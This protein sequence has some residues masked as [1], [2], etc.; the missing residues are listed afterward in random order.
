MAR[1]ADPGPTGKIDNLIFY[2]M[3]GK[4]YVRSMPRHVKQTNATKAR[5]NEFA[6]ASTIG[7]SIRSGLNPVIPEASDRK[8]KFKSGWWGLFFNG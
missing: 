7:A 2:S 3:Y 1:L 4:K 5:S 8:K 6:K